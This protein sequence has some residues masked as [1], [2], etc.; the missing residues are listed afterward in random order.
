MSHH[1]RYCRQNLGSQFFWSY[2]LY[3]NLYGIR[4]NLSLPSV[5]VPDFPTVAAAI[6][7]ILKRHIFLY[8]NGT[9]VYLTWYNAMMKI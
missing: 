9:S 5:V 3:H 6:Y 4:L 1:R 2:Q 8:I 7:Y